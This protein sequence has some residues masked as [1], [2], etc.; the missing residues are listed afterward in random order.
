M[1]RVQ[2]TRTVRAVLLFLRLYLIF[3]VGLIIYKFLTQIH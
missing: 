2:T 1:P 3:L